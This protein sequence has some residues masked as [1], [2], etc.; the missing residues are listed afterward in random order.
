MSIP[1]VEFVERYLR[2]VLPQGL[3]S[4][5]YYGFCHPAAKANRM[6]IQLQSGLPVD[7]GSTL[8]KASV[9]PPARLL[10]PC[11]RCGAPTRLV[12]FVPALF[13]NRGPPP[14]P[15]T[16]GTVPNPFSVAV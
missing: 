5:R 11:P 13:R 9:R 10:V 2:Q 3:R 15:P 6:R 12:G 7:L 4:I 14:A 16:L 8:P 1:G